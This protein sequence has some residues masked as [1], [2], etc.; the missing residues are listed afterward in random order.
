MWSRM[1]VGA[2]IGL[3]VGHFVQPGYALWLIVG[4]SAG[5]AAEVWVERAKEEKED[6][7]GL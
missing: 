6:N 2:V 7:I 5:Y 4:V 1:A 3:A